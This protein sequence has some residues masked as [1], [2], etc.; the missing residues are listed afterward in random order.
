MEW[1][2]V[3]AAVIVFGGLFYS[4]YDFTTHIKTK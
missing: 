2:V 4:L 3:A 1:I